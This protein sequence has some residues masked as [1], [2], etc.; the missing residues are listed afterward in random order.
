MNYELQQGLLCSRPEKSKCYFPI[1]HSAAQHFSLL[2]LRAGE[3]V[4]KL[5][6]AVTQ[7]YLSG[8]RLGEPTVVKIIF[9][10]ELAGDKQDVG[11]KELYSHV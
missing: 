11:L 5:R 10:L 8:V 3:I 4:T 2:C 7:P 6:I 1:L 9:S